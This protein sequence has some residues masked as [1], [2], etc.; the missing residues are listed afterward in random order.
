M[1]G[2]RLGMAVG[3]EK[4][5]GFLHTYKSQTDS[6]HFTAVMDA[7]AAALLGDQSWIGNRNDIYR[8]RRNIVVGELLRAG[9]DVTPP[10]AAIYV[11]ARLPLRFTDSST[12]CDHLLD[13]TGVSVTPG[14]VYGQFGEGYIRI[15][16]GTPTERL[17]EAMTRLSNWTLHGAQG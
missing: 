12:Y 1:A 17:A 4:I 3:N 14:V 2:W 7:G 16:L 6:S 9:F 5:I 10:P 11:W 8:H 15:S 13:A